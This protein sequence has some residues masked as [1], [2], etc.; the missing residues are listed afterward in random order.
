MP[1]FTLHTDIYSLEDICV[2]RR[3]ARN[4][5]AATTFSYSTKQQRDF[6]KAPVI[7]C[8]TTG[9]RVVLDGSNQAGDI[10][11]VKLE[12]SLMELEGKARVAWTQSLDH[13]GKIAGLEFLSVRRRQA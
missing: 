2:D 13:G 8:T 1:S 5:I 11:T 7:E 12:G 10:L 4:T 6:T 3:Q 9:A